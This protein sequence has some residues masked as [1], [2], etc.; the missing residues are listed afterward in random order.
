MHN[1]YIIFKISLIW[2]QRSFVKRCYY[3]ILTIL[4]F[5]V[6]LVLS[7][8][9]LKKNGCKWGEVFTKCIYLFLIFKLIF[10]IYIELCFDGPDCNPFL[11]ILYWKVPS[12]KLLSHKNTNLDRSPLVYYQSIILCILRTRNL[13]VVY[14]DVYS[15]YVSISLNIIFL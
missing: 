2:L 7:F 6:S 10:F 15:L 13:C 5:A 4:K 3:F 9:S 1:K 14:R 11:V 8:L 12:F